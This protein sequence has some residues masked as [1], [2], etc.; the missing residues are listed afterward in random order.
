MGRLER[1]RVQYLAAVALAVGIGGGIYALRSSQT[2]APAPPTAPLAVP[3]KG[4]ATVAQASTVAETSTVAQTSTPAHTSTVPRRSTPT[5]ASTAPRSTPQR[6]TAPSAPALFARARLA[7]A[8][9]PA[10]VAVGYLNTARL[11][12]TFILRNGKIVAGAMVG[13]AA[14]GGTTELVGTAGSPTFARAPG[15]KCW[16]PFAAS[17]PQSLTDIGSAFP[18]DFPA[19]GVIGTPVRSQGGWVISDEDPNGAHYAYLIDATTY[20]LQSMTSGYGG[21]SFTGTVDAL[22]STPVLPVPEP[23][24]QVGYL[25]LARLHNSDLVSH[26]VVV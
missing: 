1:I 8:H 12:F 23:R 2:N 18:P 14:N 17:D 6:H 10:V 3:V 5:R 11:R 25:E 22:S 9:V 26:P 16:R 13:T 19:G 4:A 21:L 15:A 20:Q 7:Y 24:C